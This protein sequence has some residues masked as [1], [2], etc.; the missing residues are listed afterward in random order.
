MEVLTGLTGSRG[1]G[2]HVVALEAKGK[3]GVVTVTDSRVKT[4]VRVVDS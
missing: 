3:V 2:G 1:G 4:A